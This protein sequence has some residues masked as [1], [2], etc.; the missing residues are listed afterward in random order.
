MRELGS[1]ATIAVDTD[2]R[3][4]GLAKEL[5]AD[6]VL[7]AEGSVDAVRELTGGRGADLVF[8]FVG[9][10]QTHA[11]AMAML[12]RGGTYSVVG[13]G[14]M[15]AVPSV[16]LVVGEQRSSAT[17]SG[18]GSISGRSCSSTQRGGSSSSRRHTRS[19][20]ST[21]CSTSS[22]RARSSGGRARFG[23]PEIAA[24]RTTG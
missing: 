8:D 21:T 4:R 15:V 6:E 7:D 17:S 19:I 14:G 24:C 5:G 11:D 18:P 12:A 16:A 3:R 10:D 22:A 13:F 2:E 9:T 1:S 20:R 23:C